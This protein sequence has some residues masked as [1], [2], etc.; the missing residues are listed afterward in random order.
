MASSACRLTPS[1]Q[2]LLTGGCI[3]APPVARRENVV[4]V[5]WGVPVPD[6]YRW[7]ESAED[8]DWL[9]FLNGQTTHARDLLDRIPGRVRH[10]Q[11]L[12]DWY[13]RSPT[14]A[15]VP[16][17]NPVQR[18]AGQFFYLRHPPGADGPALY[19]RSGK[20][21][22]PLFDA[23]GL[24]AGKSPT[25]DWW[26]VSPNGQFVVLGVSFGGGEDA[27]AYTVSTST[28]ELLAATHSRAMLGCVSWL[29]DSSG[30]FITRFVEGRKPVDTNYLSGSRVWLHRIDTDPREDILVLSHDMAG[31]QED[32]KFLLEVVEQP[33][34]DWVLG[35]SFYTT[36]VNPVFIASRS[37]VLA[38]E[39][40]WRPV[41]R[42]DDLI[43]HNRM[44]NNGISV[45]GDRIWL[46]SNQD[47]PNGKLISV[48]A[49][50]ADVSE[51]R[52]ELPESDR[53]LQSMFVSS[54]GI[55][56]QELDAGYNQLRRID[57]E[58]RVSQ[59]E[60]PIEGTILGFDAPRDADPVLVA[61]GWLDPPAAFELRAGGS[62]L[63]PLNLEPQAS[64]STEAFDWL[65]TTAKARDGVQIPVSLVFRKGVVLDGA[66]PMLMHVYGAARL[67]YEPRFDPALM[68]FIEAGGVVAVAHVR[69]GG[70]H[71]RRWSEAATGAN[72]RISYY[73]LIDC[74]EALISQGWTQPGRLTITGASGAGMVLGMA[75]TQR[76]DLFA[77]V[78][79]EVATLNM[80]RFEFTANGRGGQSPDMSIFTPEGFRNVFA[81]DGY[82]HVEEG[83][84]YPAVLL[85]H[86]LNDVRVAPWMS[87]KMA[88]ALQWA[89][90]SGKPVLLKIDFNAGHGVGSAGETHI[91]HMADIQTFALWH[92]GIAQFQPA[93]C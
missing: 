77:A 11:T 25:I 81:I 82:S 85:T 41:A 42:R 84:A 89:T 74:C 31:V 2:F 51:A 93:G 62:S 75:L 45:R 53:V 54:H 69:G 88:A 49:A 56:L 60:L 24:F 30:F 58:G 39:P 21:E 8:P 18:A 47:A 13:A 78:I 22:R 48:D 43:N 59:V 32:E 38:G 10:R 17:V 67:T 72:K 23:G 57:L 14:L 4:D 12:A 86:G 19:M 33:G 80:L 16:G 61:T 40:V 26:R 83:R 91:D 64:R 9:P 15:F 5:L 6:P 29:A 68:A 27:T 63:E 79:P 20:Q 3:A 73:D 71:G 87:A 7:M 44:S 34:E 50:S 70:E 1:S 90:S 46:L 37:S 28:S 52:I 65:K 55:Y 35:V 36:D 92:S 76:P 66:N